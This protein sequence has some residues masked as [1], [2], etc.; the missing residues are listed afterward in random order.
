MKN[1]LLLLILTL[2]VNLKSQTVVI[3]TNKLER[4]YTSSDS[5]IKIY[6]DNMITKGA[7]VFNQR[8]GSNT[9]FSIRKNLW[10][11]KKEDLDSIISNG[12]EIINFIMIIKIPSNLVDIVPQSLSSFPDRKIFDNGTSDRDVKTWFY[13]GYVN[14]DESHVYFYTKTHKQTLLSGSQ[15]LTILNLNSNTDILSVTSSEFLNVQSN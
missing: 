13:Q 6:I 11:P 7:W 15:I 8:N 5:H 9:V 12:G 4:S 1:V 2:S 10:N 14:N 3:P